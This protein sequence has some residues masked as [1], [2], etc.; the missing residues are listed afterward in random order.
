[1]NYFTRKNVGLCTLPAKEAL[2]HDKSY[3]GNCDHCNL[4]DGNAANVSYVVAECD[5]FGC[6][7]WLCCSACFTKM[8]EEEEAETVLCSDCDAPH[9]RKNL[10]R[11]TPY[12][13]YPAQGDEPLY[14]C[15]S[16]LTAPKHLARRAEDK[17]ARE[18]EE[19]RE[20]EI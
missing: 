12:D 5:S 1:M 3:G 7:T 8:L 17:A 20:T 6:E 2:F 10:H 14:L 9:Q 15:P 18:W 16:C 19:Q 4:E 13:F 11:W